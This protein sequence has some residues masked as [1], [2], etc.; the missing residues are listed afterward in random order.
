MLQRKRVWLIAAMVA[1]SSLLLSSM[2]CAGSATPPPTKARPTATV[3]TKSG[4][5]AGDTLRLLNPEAPTT[6][7]PHLST[8]IKDSE[9][10]RITLEPLATF[11][12]DGSMI[13]ML[14][15]EIP[16]RENGGLAADG[17]SVTWKLKPN[18]KWSDGS[19][20]TAEDVLFTYQFIRNS[21]VKSASAGVYGEIDSVQVVDPLAVKV[22]FKTVNPA[23]A[24]PF[25]GQRGMILAKSQFEPYNGANASQ[26]PGNTLPIGTGPYRVVPPGIKPQEVLLLGSSIIQ[27]TKIVFEPNPYFRDAAKPYFSRI[28]LRG[29]GTTSEAARQLFQENQVDYAY[30]ISLLT[31]EE[32][33]AL[34][35]SKL[36]TL[37]V[38]FGGRVERIMINR[39]DPRKVTANGERSSLQNPHPFFSDKKVRQAFAYAI[40]RESVAELFG[41]TGAATTLNLVA[42]PQYRSPNVYYSYDPQ[43]AKALL[44]EAGWRDTDGDGIRDKAGVKMKVVYQTPNTLSPQAR[45]VVQQ[46]LAAVGIEVEQKNTDSTAMFGACSASNPDAAS[47]FN[48]DMIQ[49]SIR[50]ANPDPSAYMER[51]LCSQIP[52]KAN[53]W[54]GNNRERWCS[55]QYDDLFQQARTELDPQKRA[56]LFIQMNDLLVEDVVMIP[57]VYLADGQGVANS[58]QGVDLTPWDMNTW[59]IMDWRRVAQ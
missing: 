40:H 25:V 15:A 36:G 6:L 37:A 9:A 57:V 53:N 5:G 4:R 30:N 38:S 52:Q 50:S 22:N 31:P 1:L 48:S 10:A 45:E 41:P 46:S 49:S 32:L 11:D 58:V 54:A 55:K 34:Q 28:E 16:S 14:A 59:N 8:A 20:L 2:G 51:W 3:A 29:G 17:K 47:C 27:T 21:A 26:A 44:D 42:P 23:W 19:P 39:T 13:P 24:L 56:Q 35:T 33:T 12:K 7:N 18:V 43:K